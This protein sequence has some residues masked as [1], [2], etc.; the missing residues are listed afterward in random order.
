[1][2]F[3]WLFSDHSQNPWLFQVVAACKRYWQVSSAHSPSGTETEDQ[4]GEPAVS[5]AAT[6]VLSRL[7][8]NF[9]YFP[10]PL[11][12]SLTSPGAGRLWTT[13]LSCVICSER[14]VRVALRLVNE[15]LHE[16]LHVLI[17]SSGQRLQSLTHSS[18][19]L[20]I[21]LLLHSTVAVWLRGT[22]LHADD[23][24]SRCVNFYG[25]LNSTQVY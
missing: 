5:R 18:N 7:L 12:K 22:V 21:M 4:T 14:R 9:F 6:N 13:I 2:C 8:P 25:F 19:I 11:S 15:R 23:G 16:Q 10:W 17:V 3:P 20:I 24:Y 1:M